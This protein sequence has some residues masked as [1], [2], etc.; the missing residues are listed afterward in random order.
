MNLDEKKCAPNKK[1]TN[2]SCFSIDSLKL[3]AKE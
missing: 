3:I 1:F 2:G